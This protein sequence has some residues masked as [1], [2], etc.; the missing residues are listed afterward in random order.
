[1]ELRNLRN[2]G[3]DRSVNSYL[4]AKRKPQVVKSAMFGDIEIEER[5]M[6]RMI[7]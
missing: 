1:M 6:Q 7:A 2:N 3:W 5:C 4:R